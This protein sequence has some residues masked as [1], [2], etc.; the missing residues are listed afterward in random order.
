M[1]WVAKA[2]VSNVFLLVDEFVAKMLYMFISQHSRGKGDVLAF[3]VAV[4]AEYI[5]TEVYG[6]YI[7]FIIVE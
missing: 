1:V 3:F 4:S 7:D 5:S 2:K 6:I